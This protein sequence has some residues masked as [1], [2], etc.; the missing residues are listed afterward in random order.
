MDE[1]AFLLRPRRDGWVI[2]GTVGMGGHAEAMLERSGPGV[3]VLR[4]DLDLKRRVAHGRFLVA[5]FD[6]LGGRVGFFPAIPDVWFTARREADVETRAAEVLA[7]WF[8]EHRYAEDM[9]LRDALAGLRRSEADLLAQVPRTMVM[10]ERAERRQSFILK[11]ALG[12][13]KNVI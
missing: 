6:G 8:R 1:V 3:R 4:L 2:D 11:H 7:A 13:L 5:S 10:K 9:R 12:D